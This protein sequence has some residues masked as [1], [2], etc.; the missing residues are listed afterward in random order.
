[1]RLTNFVG[2]YFFGVVF[3]LSI[4]LVI[5]LVRDGLFMD[6]MILLDSIALLS[7]WASRF[8]VV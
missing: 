6:F 4:V 2:N 1:M 3:N 7:A 8:L 5:F